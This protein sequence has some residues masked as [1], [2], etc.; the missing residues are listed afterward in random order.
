MHPTLEAMFNN[1]KKTVNSPDVDAARELCDASIWDSMDL[2]KASYRL[3]AVF[4]FF[5]TY[6]P[7]NDLCH[8]LI[9]CCVLCVHVDR[10]SSRASLPLSSPS[11]R[12]ASRL[13]S[14]RRL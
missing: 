10:L 6:T 13:K 11:V 4:L 5:T 8:E 12:A 7:F 3:E 2:D 1:I 9:F 14:S